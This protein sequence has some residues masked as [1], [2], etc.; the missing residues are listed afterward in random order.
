MIKNKLTPFKLCVLQNFPYIEEDFDALTNY[1]LM[2]KIVEYLNKTIDSQN[3]LIVE[4]NKIK[5]NLK[6]DVDAKIDE[7][8]EDGTFELLL[9]KYIDNNIKHVYNTFNLLKIADL[10]ENQKVQ[11]LGY[12]NINDGGGA[13]YIIRNTQPTNGYYETLDNGKFA[14]LIIENTMNTNCFGDGL[15]SLQKALQYCDNIIVG[16]DMEFAPNLLTISGNKNIDMNNH[17]FTMSETSLSYANLI[18]I[19]TDKSVIIKNGKIDGNLN[20]HVL[21]NV[22]N[23]TGILCTNGNCLIENVEIYNC[24]YEGIILNG[25]CKVTVENCYLHHNGRNDIAVLSWLYFK[26]NNSKFSDSVDNIDPLTNIDIEPYE[27]TSNMGV[28]IINGSTFNSVSKRHSLGTYLNANQTASALI[29]ITNN[30]FYNRVRLGYDQGLKSNYILN[31]NKYIDIQDKGAL[32]LTETVGNV[33]VNRELFVNCSNAILLDIYYTWGFIR[34]VN[35]DATITPSTNNAVTINMPDGNVTQDYPYNNINI[36]CN[37]NNIKNW[38]YLHNSEI[39]VPPLISA[40]NI[41]L[42]FN[43]YYNKIY[44]TGY[45]LNCNIDGIYQKTKRIQ[46]SITVYS[47][48]NNKIVST[49]L[50]VINSNIG[51]NGITVPGNSSSFKIKFHNYNYNKFII[52]DI[53]GLY[54]ARN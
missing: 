9:S 15:E 32:T 34:N 52:D 54:N 47:D 1:G 12:N 42:D 46:P 22:T 29:T 40:D 33:N 5:E 36:K 51:A 18:A 26:C 41:T 11:T 10:T 3:A 48:V 2:C 8:V 44:M 49:L 4:L 13:N 20:H 31:N 28:V 19:N 39:E 30:T 38:N 17:K 43:K 25:D 53:T 23:H 16:Q 14:E 50:P 45:G 21:S 7:L 24:Y 27:S 35:I 6:E 37:S